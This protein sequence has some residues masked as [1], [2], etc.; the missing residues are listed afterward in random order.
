MLLEPEP[1][2]DG[3]LEM[4]G[5]L[6]GIHGN[7]ESGSQLDEDFERLPD[8][9]YLQTERDPAP[10]LEVGGVREYLG[11]PADSDIIIQNAD[12]VAAREPVVHGE[13]YRERAVESDAEHQRDLG[14]VQQEHRAGG[15][16]AIPCEVQLALAANR[17]AVPFGKSAL[18]GQQHD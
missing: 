10:E 16:T 11:V 18:G 13:S 8:G 1:E 2:A 9:P 4:P 12:Q 14:D 15:Q 3:P 17:P 6:R 5:E 7:A